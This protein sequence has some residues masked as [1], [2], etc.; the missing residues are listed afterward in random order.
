MAAID[1]SPAD[2]RKFNTATSFG[3]YASPDAFLGQ[4]SS[5][6]DKCRR[7]RLVNVY[8]KLNRGR[9]RLIGR[10]RGNRT[11]QW[12][13]EREVPRGRYFAQVPRKRFGARG[14]H[15]CRPYRSSVL[16]MG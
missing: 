1:A 8:R 6:H 9:K 11:G 5:G 7:G 12:V 13:L 16:P 2:A 14:K 15:L 4:I 3:F 10:A